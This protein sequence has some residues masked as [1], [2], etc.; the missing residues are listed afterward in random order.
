[1]YLVVELPGPLVP[2]LPEI[3]LTLDPLFWQAPLFYKE[4]KKHSSGI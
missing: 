1:M 3:V 4:K 2:Q